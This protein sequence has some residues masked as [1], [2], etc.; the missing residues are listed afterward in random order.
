M[1]KIIRFTSNGMR[2][3]QVSHPF[4]AQFNGVG[5]CPCCNRSV[6]AGNEVVFVRYP[7]GP[8]CPNGHGP[9]IVTHLSCFE[10]LSETR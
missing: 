9:E 8:R 5:V 3:T 2:R 4:R 10:S 7:F 1:K 6:A